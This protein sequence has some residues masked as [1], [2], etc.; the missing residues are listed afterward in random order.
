LNIQNKDE[1]CFRYCLIA[2]AKGTAGSK[3]AERPAQYLNNAPSGRP[4]KNFVP[5]FTDVGLDF[6]MLSFPVELN[7]ITQFEEANN[8]GVYVFGWCQAASGGFARPVR[9]PRVVRE[10]EV[11]LLLHKG[12]YLLVTRFSALMRLDGSAHV[13]TCHR[14]I[15]SF[16]SEA[17]LKKHLE[18]GRCLPGMPAPPP[19]ASLPRPLPGSRVVIKKFSKYE[20]LHDAGILVSADL[21]TSQERLDEQRGLKRVC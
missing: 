2:W 1:F 6:S 10:R 13:H 9:A 12:H 21:E 19:T 14:C 8:I 11:Q 20:L 16:R 7:S 15:Q 5:E 4:P 18:L 3:N 17:N